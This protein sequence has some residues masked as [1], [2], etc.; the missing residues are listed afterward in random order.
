MSNVGAETCNP[1]HPPMGDLPRQRLDELVFSFAHTGVQFLRCTWKRWCC[2]FTCLTTRAEHIEVA[3]S[4]DTESCLAA[5]TRFF[6]RRGYP[7]TIISHNGT[8]F[9]GASNELKSFMDAWNKAEIEN[10]CA[11]KKDC[12]EIQ[13]PWSSTLWWNLG[14]T[15][16][17]L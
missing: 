10:D 6:E 5:V 15:E 3:Q 9:V 17:K 11:Q 1:I 2:L 4:M 7:N 13:S 12:L 14:K 8:K 16:S